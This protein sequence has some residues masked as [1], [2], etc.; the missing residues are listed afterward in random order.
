MDCPANYYEIYF[1]NKRVILTVCHKCYQHLSIL[2]SYTKLNTCRTLLI[3][4]QY[5]VLIFYYYNGSYTLLNIADNFQYLGLYNSPF[6]SINSLTCHN[7]RVSCAQ[8]TAVSFSI[9]SKI[10][11]LSPVP[12]SAETKL[13]II[14]HF[15]NPQPTQPQ[16]AKKS[17][18]KTPLLQLQFA[19]WTILTIFQSSHT[20]N[21]HPYTHQQ[22]YFSA[23]A[24]RESTV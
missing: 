11:K 21:T 17:T 20:Y 14:Y 10:T 23:E 13:R 4:L 8:K 18:V 24:N 9:G 1:W 15:S 3:I 7:S 6:T 16:L 2:S 22:V 12:A 19:C 5:K